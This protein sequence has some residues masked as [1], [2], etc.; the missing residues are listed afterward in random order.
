M[1][2]IRPIDRLQAEDIEYL[3]AKRKFW[4]T[5]GERRYLFKAEERGTGE[6]WAEKVVCELARL[7]GIPH[8][9][10]ELAHEFEGQRPIQPGVICPT[11]VPRPL[12]LLLGNELLVIRDPEYPAEENRKYGIREH[13]VE[14]VADI[15]SYLQPPASEWMGGIPLGI[16][17]SLGVYIGYIMLDAWVANQDRHHQNW[18][19]I[20]KEPSLHLA[21][22]F[23][24][25]ASLA[26]NLSDEERKERLTTR[27]QNRSVERFAGRARSGFYASPKD[28][29]TLLALDVFRQFAEK[30]PESARIWL[31]KL[32]EISQIA[33]DAVLAEIPPQ[34]M[35]PVTREFTLQLLM[36]NQ[37]RLLDSLKP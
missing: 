16:T 14:A 20:W 18:G 11:F 26:R 6:D 23:D 17:S 30:D 31:G 5:V 22:T 27:D 2:S 21:P 25:G 37:R 34:R 35:S 24:H 1:Y 36:I 29:K 9:E 7:L 32:A 3:G 19:G 4:F 33:A 15:V 8:V 12:V 10:Y 28:T 13:T